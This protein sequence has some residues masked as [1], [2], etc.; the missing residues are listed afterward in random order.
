MNFEAD[1]E[2]S[3]DSGE[4][5]ENEQNISINL[6]KSEEPDQYRKIEICFKVSIL[7]NGLLIL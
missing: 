1:G 2:M 3:T 4:D 7:E 6:I 5:C